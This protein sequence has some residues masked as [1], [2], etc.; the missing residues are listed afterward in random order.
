LTPEIK[1][2]LIR[3]IEKQSVN[4]PELKNKRDHG[5]I[6]ILKAKKANEL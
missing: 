6:E 5:L 1:E 3:G 4:I 2:K